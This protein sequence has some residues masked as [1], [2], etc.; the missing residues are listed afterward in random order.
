[1]TIAVKKRKKDFSKKKFIQ[2]TNSPPPAFAADTPEFKFVAEYLKTG[3]LLESARRFIPFK[4]ETTLGNFMLSRKIQE[5]MK[6]VAQLRADGFVISE[7]QMD[8]MLAA[9]ISFDPADAYEEDGI[10]IKNI[11]EID[12]RTRAAIEHIEVIKSQSGTI[13]KIK[14][15]S[16]HR[17]LDLGMKRRNMF[18]DDNKSKAPRVSVEIANKELG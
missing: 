18:A 9:M 16:R 10:N 11:H 8:N 3:D 2:Y 14:F 17:A 7:N 13:T 5:T 4:T 1:M 12:Q 6:F 15:T